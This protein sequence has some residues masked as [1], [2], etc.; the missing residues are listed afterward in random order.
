MANKHM[1]SCSTSLLIREILYTLL[2][3]KHKEALVI[4]NIGEAVVQLEI[5]STVNGR[6]I[7]YCHFSNQ[8]ITKLHKT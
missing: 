1:K 2:T 8:F 5:F 4:L 3:G 6:V 7:W